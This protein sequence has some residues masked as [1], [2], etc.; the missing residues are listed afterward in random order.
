VNGELDK[1]PQAPAPCFEWCSFEGGLPLADR[2]DAYALHHAPVRWLLPNLSAAGLSA[3]SEAAAA[4]RGAL[5]EVTGRWQLIH[6]PQHLLSAAL[7]LDLM[8]QGRDVAALWLFDS[9]VLV[10]RRA[11]A[12]EVWVE[13]S[14]ASSLRA[15][16]AT[17]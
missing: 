13:A 3:L 10:S 14:Y 12:I 15:L 16:L 1:D 17:L 4:G 11:A 7:P 5:T 2:G 8:L 6:I 9:P